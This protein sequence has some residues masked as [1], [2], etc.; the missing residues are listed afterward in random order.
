[1]FG[2]ATIVSGIT[3]RSIVIPYDALIEADGNRAF[4]FVPFDSNRVNRVP[5]I[6][7]NFDDN[8]NTGPEYF[9]AQTFAKYS[10]K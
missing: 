4:V 10:K 8:V 7:K 2:K 3:K 6:I 1:M 9:S 5:V